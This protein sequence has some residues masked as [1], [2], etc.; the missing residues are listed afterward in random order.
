[1]RRASLFPLKILVTLK[2]RGTLLPLLA[3]SALSNA[4]AQTPVIEEIIVSA[5]YRESEINDIASSVSVLNSELM[6]QRNAQHLEDILANAPNVNFASGASRARFY[7]IRG[8]G[9]RG[10]FAEP[11][12]SSVG[13][14]IDGVD[15]SGIGNAALLYDVEQV[16][17][18][19]GPQG[20]RYGSN[21]LAGLINLQSKAATGE[22]TYGFKLESGN[23][24]SNGIAGYVSGPISDRLRY[25]VSAQSINSDGYNTNLYLNAKTNQRDEISV[26][27]KLAWDVS[28]DVQL[29]LTAASV[30]MDNGYDAFS[31]DNVRDTLSDQ[32]GFD[33]QRSNL[34]S[35]RLSFNQ[36]EKFK[37]QALLGLASSETEYGY[38]EDWVFPGFH[39]WEY[40]ST[41]N[42]FRDRDTRSAE[43]RL[44][45]T[46][47]GLIFSDS[48]DW[49]VGIYSLRQEV[50]LTRVYTF[51]ATD[52]TSF[53][54]IN[55]LAIYG[56]LNSSLAD[57]LSLSIGLRG[58]VFDATY[59]DTAA[60]AFQPD[61]NLLGGKVALSYT[62]KND[63]LLYASISRGYKAGGFNTDGSLDR[64][65]REFDSE[66]LWNY[67]I[68][69]KGF[70]FN[71]RLQTQLALFH[72]DRDDV[73]ISSSLTRVRND[74]SAEFIDF[75]GNAA[76]GTNYGLEATANYYLNDAVST[77]G[78]F[79]LLET[80]YRDFTNSA[81]DDLSGRRQAHAPRYQ[82]T[83]GVN[84]RISS[85]LNLDVNVQGKD[86]FFFSDT[87]N[88]QSK[89]YNL[90]N[91]SLNYQWSEWQLTLWG[92]NLGDEDYFVRG[93]FFGNDP[94]DFYTARGFTQLGEPARF[95]LTLNGDF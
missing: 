44:Q 54:D 32:P 39:P 4:Q 58:E 24:R 73:Q 53:Y 76:A 59:F 74:G 88:V 48:T 94:R 91:A 72:M 1:M 13:V 8:I 64:D 50:N 17:I 10:Q 66:A 80:E 83:V 71:D 77:Y 30:D 42:Y 57:N 81:G 27:G 63:G 33:R 9:E 51:L 36:F 86:E 93:F 12:N 26:R 92:R 16:E 22:N 21:A 6:Q 62:T 79:G 7:Q 14:I 52:F 89:S 90:I 78:S 45:S 75:I 40:A 56:E 15:F 34:L 67:E 82:Y 41:D 31:L 47:S 68:G 28:E 2:P 87:H 95:G 19:L 11:L 5:D 35:G 85:A 70:S 18:L 29:D 37:V 49:I 69:F 20:T 23:Y 61:E 65:L 38:D 25:R 55:R 60:V 3:V 84:W 43:L 46:D